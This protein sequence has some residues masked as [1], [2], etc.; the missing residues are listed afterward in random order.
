M[1]LSMLLSYLQLFI[2]LLSVEMEGKKIPK[3]NT[4]W[5]W[6]APVGMPFT[7]NYIVSY[8]KKKRYNKI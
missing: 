5:R 1:P 8:S 2:K 4:N 6:S 7:L 3:K